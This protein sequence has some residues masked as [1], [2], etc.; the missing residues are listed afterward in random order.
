MVDELSAKKVDCLVKRDAR[1]TG[2]YARWRCRDSA[3]EKGNARTDTEFFAA[4]F[5]TLQFVCGQ[6]NKGVAG[7]LFRDPG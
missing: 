6:R 1:K 7:L 5:N 3:E 2:S 4:L